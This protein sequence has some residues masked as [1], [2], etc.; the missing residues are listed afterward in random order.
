MEKGRSHDYLAPHD[1]SANAPLRPRSWHAGVWLGRL[2][3][4]TSPVPGVPGRQCLLVMRGHR[5]AGDGS[6]PSKPEFI[7]R[8]WLNLEPQ[9]FGLISHLPALAIKIFYY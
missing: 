8:G 1:Q 9:G 7:A 2:L 6:V 4:V 3:A 5:E